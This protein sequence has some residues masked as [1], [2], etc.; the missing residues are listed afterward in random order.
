MFEYKSAARNAACRALDSSLEKGEQLF[1]LTLLFT[2]KLIN[3]DG[4]S[5]NLVG[6]RKGREKWE[7]AARC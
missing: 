6:A 2:N 3:V 7:S 5:I 1:E 4:G